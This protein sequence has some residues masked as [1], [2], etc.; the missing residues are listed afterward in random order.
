M[1]ERE[2]ISSR[3]VL[4]LIVLS[5]IYGSAIVYANMA[6]AAKIEVWFFPWLL[7][8]AGTIAYSVTFPVTDI[9][10]EVY[11][12]RWAYR[13]VWA[14]LAAEILTLLLALGDTAI[15][16][17]PFMTESEVACASKVIGLQP[18]IVAASIVA[19]LVSQHHDVWAF[20]KWRE[21]TRGRWLW[22][23]NNAS[24][25]VSQL[26]DTTIFTTLAFWGVYP[27]EAIA[28]M[29]LTMW[30]AKVLIALG[31]TPFVYLGVSLLQRA[32]VRLAAEA[33]ARRTR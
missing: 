4:A 28:S 21:I 19:Y 11:G 16:P 10:D 6:A 13:I 27:L 18:R 8:P 32:G 30:L 14:G 29:I 2:A 1:A 33:A 12:K 31:D 24:T 7:V 17:A 26:I 22:V 9:V 23:R 25:A 15:P 3:D 20:W 5:A